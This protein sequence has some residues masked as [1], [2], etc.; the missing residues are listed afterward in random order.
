MKKTVISAFY[1]L[2]LFVLLLPIPADAQGFKNPLKDG[3]DT[4]AG[5]TD[6]FLKAVVYILFPLAVVFVVYSGFLFITAQGSSEGLGKAKK[7]F[8][9]TIIGVGLLLGA[10]A[11]A[12]LVKSTVD[13]LQ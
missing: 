11:L 4:V 3:L 13:S 6:A 1:T 12:V 7:N 8:F 2:A 9:W 5:F 10:S